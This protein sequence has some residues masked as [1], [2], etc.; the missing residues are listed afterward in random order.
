M[1]AISATCW[2]WPT[3][4]TVQFLV[5]NPTTVDLTLFISPN[6]LKSLCLEETVTVCVLIVMA[7]LGWKNWGPANSEIEC[8]DCCLLLSHVWLFCDLMDC[9]P[10]SPTVLGIFQARI[11]E[12]VAISF[13]RGSSQLRDWTCIS[14]LE[15]KFFTTEPLGSPECKD[16]ILEK[17]Q[18]RLEENRKEWVPVNPLKRA[19]S[20][21]WAIPHASFKMPATEWL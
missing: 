9:S 13:T 1:V 14:C 16:R 2:I 17:G 3:E 5:R 10:P 7:V 20:S 21:N 15:G 19:V 12:W 18:R 4:S 8:K 11:L 6:F